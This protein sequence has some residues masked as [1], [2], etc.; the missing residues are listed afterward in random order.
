MDKINIELHENCENWVMYEFAK[1]LGITPM[2]LIAPNKKPRISDVRQ[3]YCK[4]R[5]EL[6]G[7]TFV[8]LGEELGRAHTTV[9][10]GV[11]R[12]NDLLRLN[13]KR[14]LAMWNRVRDISE[15][16]I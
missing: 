5:Y 2:Q 10:Y 6:H 8:E 7:L 12:I 9:R 16:P 4:L 15:L 13:D 3:L 11:L 1:R 14:T